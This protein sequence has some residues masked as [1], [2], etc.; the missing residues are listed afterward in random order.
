MLPRVGVRCQIFNLNP[1][2]KIYNKNDVPFVYKKFQKLSPYLSVKVVRNSSGKKYRRKRKQ[3]IPLIA[4]KQQT[5]VYSRPGLICLTIFL[6][7]SL[8]WETHNKLKKTAD[9]QKCES[10]GWVRKFS[11]EPWEIQ[12]VNFVTRCFL[13]GFENSPH[14]LNQSDLNLIT[15]VFPRFGQFDWFF[16]PVF[17]CFF[18]DLSSDLSLYQ[19]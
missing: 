2:R 12:Y 17:F 1:I 13:I 3:Y 15:I 18:L 4:V 10:A 8:K 9:T 11:Y 6:I 5:L 19:I 7:R 16:F 14:P